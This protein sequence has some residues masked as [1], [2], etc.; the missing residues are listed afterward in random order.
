[1]KEEIN[2][3]NVILFIV[4]FVGVNALFEMVIATLVSGAVG[5]A[6]AKAKLIDL[7]VSEEN[8]QKSKKNNK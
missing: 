1:M 5:N 4:T 3:K 7:P 6:L 2:G 8:S